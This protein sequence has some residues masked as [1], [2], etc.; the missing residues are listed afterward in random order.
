MRLAILSDI[1]GNPIALDAV[2]RD[3]HDIGGIDGYWILGDLAA[4][5]FD[6]LGVLRKVRDLPDTTVI[7]GNTDRYTV[8]ADKAA[9]LSMLGRGLPTSEDLS[10][11]IPPELFPA[12]VTVAQ[13]I[14]WTRGALAHGDWL[15]WLGSLPIDARITLPDGTRM[16]G[17]HAS[18]GRDDGPGIEPDDADSELIGRFAGCD[19]D[20]VFVGHT[21]WQQERHIGDVHVVNIGNVSN[22]RVGLSPDRRATY[23]ILDADIDGY[24]VT[25]RRVA[26]DLSAVVQA[27][28]DSHFYPN[29]EWLLA[30]FDEEDVQP[31]VVQDAPVRGPTS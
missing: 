2:L 14:A 4:Q 17:V 15:A 28:H 22:P 5:G 23:A 19:A 12:Y 29:P 26:Y 7:R 24:Q 31:Q 27:I 9:I 25:P 6:P 16:L 3:A 30:K 8:E 10:A 20:L 13:G 18:P 1:H 11:P 21:H